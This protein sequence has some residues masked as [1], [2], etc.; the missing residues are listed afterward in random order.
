[1][2]RSFFSILGGCSSVGRAVRLV[3]ESPLPWGGT[4]LHV[5]VSLSKILN[6]KI[7]SDVQLAPCM[8][9]SA[10]SKGWLLVQGV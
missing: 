7:A 2:H 10:I 4:G 8:A 1:M 6:P 9:A 5:K 3:I